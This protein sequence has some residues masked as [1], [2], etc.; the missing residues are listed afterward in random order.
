VKRKGY[1]S[2]NLRSAYSLIW[3]Q[4]T[5]ALRSKLRA[6]TEFETIAQHFDCVELLKLIKDT[7]FKFSSQKYKPHALHEAIRRFYTLIQDKNSSCEDHVRKFKNQV[8]VVEH[9]GG[10]I[11]MTI[12][13]KRTGL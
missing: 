10:D 6:K 5:E 12:Q 2:E 3:G 1:L 7:V 9:C 4:C 11:G 8:E 13:L